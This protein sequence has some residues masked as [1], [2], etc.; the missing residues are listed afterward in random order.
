MRGFMRVSCVIP[1]ICLG[2]LLA[3][4]TSVR[5]SQFAQ[6]ANA[7]QNYA[8]A[9]AVLTEKAGDAAVNADS[10]VLARVHKQL[11]P[12]ARLETVHEHNQLLQ[13]RLTVLGDIRK[14]AELLKSYF[15]TLAA[16]AESKAPASVGR[17]AERFVQA[18]AR[19]SPELRQTVL[20]ETWVQELT[21]QTVTVK[22]GF[23]RRCSLEKELKKH[24]ALIEEEL[25][26]QERV[27]AEIAAQM[28]TDLEAGLEHLI[29]IE[30]VQ[31]YQD[32]RQLPKV[33][34]DRRR[35]ILTDEASLRYADA[36]T[37]AAGKLKTAFADLAGNRFHASSMTAVF[38][39]LEKVLGMIDKL[40]TGMDKEG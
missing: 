1:G 25:A 23:F 31:K 10:L 19:V 28:K 13:E 18:L 6:F 8:K 12:E 3:G 17:E 16:L 7:G 24:A 37:Q 39:D 35:K 26:V 4:C 36:A 29:A 22:V 20:G 40:Q 11:T 32:G 34:T 27:L 9:V 38:D 30:I 5:I 33:W 2:L 14:H 21:E 15:Q